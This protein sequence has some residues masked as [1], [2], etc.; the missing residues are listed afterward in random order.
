LKGADYDRLKGEL[1]ANG[2]SAKFYNELASSLRK[3]LEGSV[4][5]DE[6]WTVNKTNGAIE[7][8]DGVLF[9]LGS[10]KISAKGAAILK[11]IADTQR[12]NVV[13]VVGHTDR[14]PITREATIKALDTK[15][16]MELS[17]RRATAVMGELL[18]H[19]MRESQ[20]ASVEGHGTEA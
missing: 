9:D 13:K 8:K 5:K 1:E 3:A 6:D 12:Q 14:K 10:W 19:G 17:C 18:K 7:F 16:N 15:T 20:F 4:V 11:A 2:E